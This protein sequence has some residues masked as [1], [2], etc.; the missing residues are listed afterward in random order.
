MKSATGFN[1][2]PPIHKALLPQPAGNSFYE[3]M[4]AEEDRPLYG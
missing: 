1:A 3:G 4:M 2:T